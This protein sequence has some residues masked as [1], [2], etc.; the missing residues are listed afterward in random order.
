MYGAGSTM[1]RILLFSAEGLRAFTCFENLLLTL[2]RSYILHDSSNVFILLLLTP[3]AA[4]SGSC[5]HV[6]SLSFLVT[7]H[8]FEKKV[9]IK[10]SLLCLLALFVHSLI[11]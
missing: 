4:A 5:G 1:P 6:K 3:G 11:Y 7:L 2:F 8:L 10:S 9:G